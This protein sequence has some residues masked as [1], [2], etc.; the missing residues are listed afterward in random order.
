MINSGH[1]IGSVLRVWKAVQSHGDPNEITDPPGWAIVTGWYSNGAAG[2]I[3][4]VA[5]LDRELPTIKFLTT[6]TSVERWEVAPD[7]EI[8]PRIKA[9]LAAYRLLGGEV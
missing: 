6:A 9:A 3:P 8:P 2:R 7:D 5:W 1:Q 4:N